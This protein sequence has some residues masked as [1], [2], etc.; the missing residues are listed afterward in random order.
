MNNQT[1]VLYSTHDLLRLFLF[2]IVN[3]DD[4]LYFYLQL[5]STCTMKIV[6][7]QSKEEFY[8]AII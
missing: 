3:Y 5:G 6:N 4:F 8:T 7:E 2:K 1:N